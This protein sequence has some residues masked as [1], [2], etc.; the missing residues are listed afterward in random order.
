M[1]AFGWHTGAAVA[2]VNGD[3]L[4]DVFVAGYTD[5]NAMI[6]T[7]SAGFPANHR[8][9]P[10]PL[11]LNEGGHAGFREVGAQAGL[12]PR[13]VDHGLGAVFLD[14]N[15]DGRLDLY[16]ANDLDPNRLYLNLAKPDDRGTWAS[17]SSSADG[18]SASTTRTPGWALPS[19]TSRATGSRTCSSRTRA[20]SCTPRTRAPR[21]DRTPT[22]APPSRG[23]S[24]RRARG[25]APRGPTS[26]STATWSSPWRTGRFP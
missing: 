16:V 9:V 15:R 21:V 8:G 23:R 13:H 25:G 11:Y 7:S 19:A 22:R 2:D 4:L 24:G 18:A 20:V 6:P 17:A 10:D 1:R 26:T 5:Q 14:A 3:G 12:E